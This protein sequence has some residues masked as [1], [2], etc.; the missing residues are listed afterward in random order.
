MERCKICAL[1]PTEVAGNHHQR[2]VFGCAAAETEQVAA[3]QPSLEGCGA[4][5]KNPKN[6]EIVRF[7]T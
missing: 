5:E 1:G 2:V 3:L 4:Q 6:I 7:Q